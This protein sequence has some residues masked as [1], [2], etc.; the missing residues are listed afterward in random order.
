MFTAVAAGS[1]AVTEA[2]VVVAA[3]CAA[4]ASAAL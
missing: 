2:G 1:P 3:A 4:A